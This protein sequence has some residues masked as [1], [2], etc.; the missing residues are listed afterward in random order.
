MSLL[1]R[2]GVRV[3]PNRVLVAMTLAE[4]KR[5]LSM[6]ELEDRI[7]TVDKSG[8]FRTLEIFKE[9]HLVHG[10]RNILPVVHK[11]YFRSKAGTQ[12]CQRKV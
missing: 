9:H 8:I 10:E 1:G 5:P 12:K 2:H 6:T 7:E 11:L 4:E 3:T